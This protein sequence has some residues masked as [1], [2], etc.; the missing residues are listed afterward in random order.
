MRVRAKISK[1]RI[2]RSPEE[3]SE[4]KRLYLEGNSIP[5]VARIFNLDVRTIYHYLKPL[6]KEEKLVHLQRSLDREKPI[7]DN[8]TA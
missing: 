6:S 2:K 3:L 5:E 7:N 4:I 1:P 8:P